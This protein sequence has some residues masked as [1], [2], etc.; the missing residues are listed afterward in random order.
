[1]TERL[2]DEY[3]TAMYADTADPWQ[4]AER[5]YERRKYAI[6]VAM[7]PL[8]TY[9]H[10]FEP[11]CSI[12]VLTELLTRRCDHVTATDVAQRA[13]A[14][15]AARLGGSGRLDQVTLRRMSIDSP[16]PA[17]QFDLVVLSEVAYYLSATMLRRVLDRECARLAPGTTVVASHWRHRVADYP[18]TG[19]E[20]NAVIAETDDL[21]QTAEYSDDD[22]AIAVFG[23]GTAQSVAARCGV[24]GVATTAEHAAHGSATI[25]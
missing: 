15:A 23:K 5:W 16:W 4:L 1:V 21:Y 14:A 20:A 3:F 25:G 17:E 9:R 19:D 11:G 10:A 7:L 13:L 18:L 12:G 8:P 2:P 24:P 22:V 6:T